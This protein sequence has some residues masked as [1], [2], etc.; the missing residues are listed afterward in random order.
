MDTIVDEGIPVD[1]NVVNVVTT[2][3]LKV[4]SLGRLVPVTLNLPKFALCL[5]DV[6]PLKCYKNFA[7]A[8]LVVEGRAWG[9]KNCVALIFRTGNVV[10]TGATT[11]G[12]ALS[13]AQLIVRALTHTSGVRFYMTRFLIQNLVCDMKMKHEDGTPMKLDLVAM[14]EYMG[15]KAELETEGPRAFPA[16]R[17]RPSD[18]ASVILAYLSGAAVFTGAKN[19]QEAHVNH[20]IAYELCKEFPL[21]EEDCNMPKYMMHARKRK[22]ATSD[23]GLRLLDVRLKKTRPQLGILGLGDGNATPQRKSVV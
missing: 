15:N 19:R 20:K 13:V 4:E 21:S 2:F 16:C 11:E 9:Y 7:A 8:T 5:K 14:N 18:D 6:L 12:R 1:G 3:R 10:F 22:R 23:E 17:V